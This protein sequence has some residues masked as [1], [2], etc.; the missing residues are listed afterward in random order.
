LNDIGE[1][2][3][4]TAANESETAMKPSRRTTP[5]TKSR[6]AQADAHDNIAAPAPDSSQYV[7]ARS[8]H[9]LGA[10]AEFYTPLSL[11]SG[12]GRQYWDE[13][14][15]LLVNIRS[16]CDAAAERLGFGSAKDDGLAAV[17]Y[18]ANKILEAVR[19]ERQQRTATPKR[20]SPN[21][22]S[23]PSAPDLPRQ[24]ATAARHKSDE[25]AQ[26]PQPA[27]HSERSQLIGE[28]KQMLRD[29]KTKAGAVIDPPLA[30]DI[31][32]HITI[33]N[34]GMAGPETTESI[35][36]MRER[37]GPFL[38]RL[39]GSLKTLSKLAYKPA[40]KAPAA[41]AAQRGKRPKRSLSRPNKTKKARS[42]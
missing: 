35:K 22:P 1:D 40:A 5:R 17:E 9:R 31:A 4:Q 30:H 33:L 8:E 7:F 3:I 16:D 15:R 36:Q 38:A 11:K 2:S 34:E 32:K 42:R 14:L 28:L 10:S 20:P 12:A 26:P 37:I 21:K 29:G 27:R 25:P 18:I 41:A 24:S 13:V 23:A 39:S 19:G 6:R